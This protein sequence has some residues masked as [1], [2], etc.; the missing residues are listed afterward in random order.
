VKCGLPGV[1]TDHWSE[2]GL[3]DRERTGKFVMKKISLRGFSSVVVSWFY[4]PSAPKEGFR[5]AFQNF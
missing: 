2:W 5:D 4:D 3:P 1:R